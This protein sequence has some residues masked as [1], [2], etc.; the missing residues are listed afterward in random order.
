MLLISFIE[1]I[2]GKK[3]LHF[4]LKAQKQLVKQMKIVCSKEVENLAEWEA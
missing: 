2:V 1:K 3:L 4:Y